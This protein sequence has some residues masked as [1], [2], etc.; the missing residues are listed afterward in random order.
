[1][2][3]PKILSFPTWFGGNA[4][5]L[6]KLLKPYK[7]AGSEKP[8]VHCAARG[9]R[10]GSEP[11]TRARARRRRKEN[12]KASTARFHINRFL[13]NTQ[14]RVTFFGKIFSSLGKSPHFYRDSLLDRDNILK[15]R[16]KP[17]TTYKESRKFARKKK[18][19]QSGFISLGGE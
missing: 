1:M 15:P 3:W 11:G 5:N 4:A 14:P 16:L 8:T 17:R 10:Y 2:N 7:S 12:N 6:K 13:L 9:E 19:R 18:K